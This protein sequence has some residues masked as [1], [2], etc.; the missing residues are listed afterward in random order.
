MVLPNYNHADL[1]T[2][3]NETFW[4][5]IGLQDLVDEGYCRIGT[6]VLSPG[7][8]VGDGLSEISAIELGLPVKLPVATAI[9][10]AHAGGLGKSFQSVFN[11]RRKQMFF[12]L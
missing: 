10:D 5:T 1:T 7:T 3:W 9:I 11:V 2:G 12:L 6:V 4:K 8:P